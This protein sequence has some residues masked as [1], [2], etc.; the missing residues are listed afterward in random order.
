[1][2]ARRRGYRSKV[3]P[4]LT[5]SL[6][7]RLPFAPPYCQADNR[8]TSYGIHCRY[9]DPYNHYVFRL[10]GYGGYGVYKMR[11]GTDVRL[12]GT[13]GVPHPV[14]GPGTA[15]NHLR[16][17]CVGDT[18]T[19]VVNGETVLQVTNPDLG[20]GYVGLYACG[21]GGSG[22]EVFFQ[23]FRAD[24]PRAAGAAPAT[25]RGRRDTLVPYRR[26]GD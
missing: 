19:L 20:E 9:Q 3:L 25:A 17:E 1:M 26:D 5:S 8:T 10:L 7:R 24:T 23:H 18:L 16:A 2:L 13:S 4:R 11:G 21:C 6:H 22:V 14:V 15:T 12:G